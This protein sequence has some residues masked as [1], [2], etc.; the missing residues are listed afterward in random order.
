M[1]HFSIGYQPEEE[2]GNM[3][4]I[5][6]GKQTSHHQN[7]RSDRKTSDFNRMI[8]TYLRLISWIAP[9]PASGLMK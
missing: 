3:F 5:V 8:I 4:T 2:N 7:I 9:V 1:S 6:F